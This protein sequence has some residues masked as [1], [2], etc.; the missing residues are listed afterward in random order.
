MPTVMFG[1]GKEAYGKT[2]KPWL[3]QNTTV[4]WAWGAL[5]ACKLRNQMSCNTHKPTRDSKEG[6]MYCPRTHCLM[7]WGWKLKHQFHDWEMTALRLSHSRP[8][9]RQTGWEVHA[10]ACF[11]LTEKKKQY[12]KSIHFWNLSKNPMRSFLCQTFHLINQM[13]L[14]LL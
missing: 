10:H 3:Q 12:K 2:L 9:T 4:V 8:K 13:L 7:T 5:H 11:T 6:S 1:Q 14:N